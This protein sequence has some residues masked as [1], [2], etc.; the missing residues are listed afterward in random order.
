V[1]DGAAPGLGPDQLDALALLEDVDV[2]A[3]VPDALPVR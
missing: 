2:V 3:D 1:L